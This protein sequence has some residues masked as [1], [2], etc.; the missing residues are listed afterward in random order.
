MESLKIVL[1]AVVACVAYGVVHDQ[2]TARICVEY[3]TVGHDD[4]FGTQDPTLLAIG[5]GVIAAWWVGVLVG[6][7]LAIAARAGNAAKWTA[8]RLVRPMLVLVAV[9]AALAAVAGV[10]GYF[11]ASRDVVQ[12][13]GPIAE[14]LPPEKHVPFLVDLWMHNASYAGGFFRRP[15]ARGVDLA[16]Q[17]SGGERCA[18]ATRLSRPAPR[19]QAPLQIDRARR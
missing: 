7:P 10:I 4:R 13:V 6:I 15:D 9:T 19:R 1:L 17:A 16:M 12:L 18:A 3:F 5:W 14:R 11:A 8:A 2:F